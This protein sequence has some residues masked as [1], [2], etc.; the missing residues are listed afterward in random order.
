MKLENRKGRVCM[1]TSSMWLNF[2]LC[3]FAYMHVYNVLGCMYIC[4]Q[5]QPVCVFCTCF[6]SP[7]PLIFLWAGMNM[8]WLVKFLVRANPFTRSSDVVFTVALSIQN[9]TLNWFK[10]TYNNSNRAKNGETI[11][12]FWEL[13]THLS[14]FSSCLTPKSHGLRA[15]FAEK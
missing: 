7:P 9:N 3:M 8:N 1:S 11:S 14:Y 10:G 12:E 15:T 2:L 13:F 6:L 5:D 4:V